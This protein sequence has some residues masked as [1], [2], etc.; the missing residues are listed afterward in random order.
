MDYRERW[1]LKD[2]LFGRTLERRIRCSRSAVMVLLLAGSCSTSGTSRAVHGDEYAAPGREQP[3]AADPVMAAD[4]R[5][6]LRPHDEVLAATRPSLDLVLLREGEPDLEPQL[7]GWCRFS[8]LLR[9]TGRSR[10]A[11]A[12]PPAFEPLD[13]QGGRRARRAGA[14]SRRA[15]RACFPRWRCAR[16]RAAAIRTA[17]CSVPRARL[18]RRG[19]RAVLGEDLRARLHSA[20]SSARPGSSGQYDE[21]LRGVRGWDLVSVNNL[22]R[23][24]GGPWVGREPEHGA[25]ISA[26]ARPAIFNAH[27]ARVSGRGRR[28]GV[29]R[30][31][32]RRGAGPTV[33]RRASTPTCSP[34]ACRRGVETHHRG[35]AASAARPRDRQ[36]TTRPARCSRS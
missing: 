8:T 23:R 35:P 19:G 21:G 22:G 17:S 5:R 18:R 13:P 31:V 25:A 9:G 12:R 11:D 34:T 36:L 33:R 26:D 28:R 10:R 7:R 6:D 30:S 24:I 32:D 1:E 2:Y 27:C 14:R 4:A 3:T 20:T 15:A 16:P 29:S